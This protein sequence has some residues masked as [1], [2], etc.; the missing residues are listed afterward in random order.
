MTN[1][2]LL[3][4]QLLCHDT[5]CTEPGGSMPNPASHY[6]A[7]LRGVDIDMGNNPRVSAISMSGAQLCSIEDV[8][9]M[10]AAFYAGVV[11]LPG[12]GGFTVNLRVI[13]G[14]VG[15]WQNEFRPNPSASGVFLANQSYAGVLLTNARGPLVLSGFVITGQGSSYSGVVIDTRAADGA[16]SLENAALA[17]EDGSISAG[18]GGVAIRNNLSHDTSLVNVHVSA[19]VAVAYGGGVLTAVA[20]EWRVIRLWS[21]SKAGSAMQVGG[22]NF[23]KGTI[24]RQLR[25]TASV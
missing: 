15:V 5:K 20:G 22:R 25:P 14:V 10:G 4:Y 2:T 12:S 24:Q 13:G 8:T 19:A 18:G 3:Y 11:G 6:S 21:F 9:I 1:N 7:M 16:A 23:T 17:L